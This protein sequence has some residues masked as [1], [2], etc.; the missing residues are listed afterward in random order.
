M[1]TLFN[2][3][4]TLSLLISFVSCKND[5]PVKVL[6]ITGGHDYDKENFDA[7]LAK[8]PIVYDQ[9]EHPDAH[10]M[11]KPDKIEKYDVILLY[12]MPQEISP[13]AQQDFITML[14]KGKGLVVL[15]HAFCAY[16][17]WPEYTKIVGGRYHH[18]PWMKDGIEQ[19]VSDYTHDVNLQIH[20]EDKTHFIT[21]GIS[22]FEIIDEAYGKTEILPTVHPLLS[23]D[24]SLS[25]PLVCWTNRYGNSRIVTL[26]LGH[27]KQSW[28]NSSF[29]KVLSQ[30]ILWVKG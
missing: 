26:T 3:L 23:T 11:L 6:L 9:V 25:G 7:M 18:F 30:A 8:L 1:K 12:D 14:E 15:H 2:L 10:A 16:D 27:D 21:K 20:I 17:H 24:N 19:P 13:E 28:E 5:A 4:F 22:D 29:I